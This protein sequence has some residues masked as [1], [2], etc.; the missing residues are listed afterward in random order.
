[1]TGKRCLQGAE[2]FALAFCEENQHGANLW[3][4]K[5]VDQNILRQSSQ[6]LERRSSCSKSTITVDKPSQRVRFQRSP[7]DTSP[8]LAP[9]SVKSPAKVHRLKASRK[10]RNLLCVMGP[11]LTGNRK[12]FNIS[13]HSMVDSNEGQTSN[14][15]YQ[16]KRQKADLCHNSSET[17]AT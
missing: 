1:M 14:S 6:L 11:Q 10:V 16:N 17:S 7:P 8:I 12:L 2:E 5:W 3:P 4:Q 9:F 15:A 13:G